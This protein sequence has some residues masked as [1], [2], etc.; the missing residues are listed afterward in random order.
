M[1]GIDVH[2]GNQLFRQVIQV[3]YCFLNRASTGTHDDDQL[4]A[5]GGHS[6]QIIYR[7]GR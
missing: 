3:I 5:W 7:N 1:D 6:I 2:A 4:S